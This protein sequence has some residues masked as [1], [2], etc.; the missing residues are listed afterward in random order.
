MGLAGASAGVLS[1]V[2]VDVWGF[3]TL[4][5]LAA[6]ATIPFIVLAVMSRHWLVEK[7]RT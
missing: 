6:L 1:G 4:A 3:P 7:I 2:I 5:L